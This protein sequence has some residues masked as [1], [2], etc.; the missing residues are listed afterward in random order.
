[1]VAVVRNYFNI[2][3]ARVERRLEYLNLLTRELGSLE[4]AD[5]FLGLAREH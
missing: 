5:E 2:G 1:M 3:I 4:A